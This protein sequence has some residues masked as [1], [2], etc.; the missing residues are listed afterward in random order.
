LYPPHLPAAEALGF[1]SQI[2]DTVEVNTTFHAW[3]QSVLF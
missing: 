3:L 2:F 1:Y